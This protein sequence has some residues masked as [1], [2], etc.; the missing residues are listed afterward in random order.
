MYCSFEKG[1]L[2]KGCV[3]HAPV[4]RAASLEQLHILCD[5]EPYFAKQRNSCFLPALTESDG[6]ICCLESSEELQFTRNK[7]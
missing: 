4:Y 5:T 7:K 3:S 6:K 2:I 1:C